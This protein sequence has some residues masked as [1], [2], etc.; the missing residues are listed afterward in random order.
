MLHQGI[1][2]LDLRPLEPK[3]QAKLHLF[4]KQS[5]KRVACL[6]IQRRFNVIMDQSLKKK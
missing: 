4:W 5:I 1:K 3:N 6:N 2:S